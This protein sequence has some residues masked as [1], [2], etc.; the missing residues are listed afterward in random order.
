[1]AFALVMADKQWGGYTTMAK[2]MLT[3][4]AMNDFPRTGRSRGV[5]CT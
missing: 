5:T 2:N 3:V 1:M 4:V